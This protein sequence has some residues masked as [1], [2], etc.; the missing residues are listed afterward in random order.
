MATQNVA[1]GNHR[2]ASTYENYLMWCHIWDIQN[3]PNYEQWLHIREDGRAKP[4]RQGFVV[5][6]EGVKKQ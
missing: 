1:L 5:G 2:L 3:P 6:W 4:E